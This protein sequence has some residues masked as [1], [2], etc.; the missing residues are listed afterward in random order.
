MKNTL[1][2]D[3]PEKL[4]RITA[5]NKFSE[6][7]TG[8][9]NSAVFHMQ[10]V[11]QYGSAY[12]KV[13]QYDAAETLADEAAVLDWLKE[14]IPVPEVYYY[15]HYQEK[16]YLLMSEIKGFDCSSAVHKNSPENMVKAF[17][18]GLKAIHNIEITNCPFKRTLEKKI[19][20]ARYR[21]ENGLVDEANFEEENWGK[22]AV[23]LFET[24][25]SKKTDD[26]DLVFTHGDYCLPN[27]IIDGNKLSGLIDLGRGGVADRYQD[28]ALA[29]RSLKHNLQSEK[30]VDL[31]FDHYGMKDVNDAKIDF[32]ILLDEFF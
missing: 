25:L 7:T 6:N 13:K 31:F 28:I 9:S 1:L 32:Y 14:K 2:Y 15:K 16:E 11:H 12:L 29:V 3:M 18:E 5:N 22:K 19:D 23:D 27:V 30:W 4:R 21:V 26:E 17:A 10:N 24:L 8:C 20:K